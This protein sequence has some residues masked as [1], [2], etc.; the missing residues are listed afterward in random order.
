MVCYQSYI[1]L[2][3]LKKLADNTES[4]LAFMADST[5]IC[6]D[7]DDLRVY[8]YSKYAGEIKSLIDDLASSGHIVYTR[9][10][11]YFFSLTTKGIH[12]LQGILAKFVEFLFKS[13]IVPILA[14]AGTTLLLFAL[15]RWLM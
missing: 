11:K 1:V 3:H 4:E 13:I 10:N 14:A 12:P 2:R 7:Y 5:L 6:A 9:E 15:E 8:D